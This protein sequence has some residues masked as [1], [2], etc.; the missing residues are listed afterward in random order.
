MSADEERILQDSFSGMVSLTRDQ[1]IVR[2]GDHPTQCSLLMDGYVYRYKI[3]PDGKRQILAF[4]FR[5]EIFDTQSFL[6]DT[7]DH[8]VA[9]LTPATIGVVTHAAMREITERFPRITRALWKETLAE[10]AIFR[11]WLVSVGRRPAYERLA[12]L[13]CETYVRSRSVE[14]GTRLS[15]PWPF[16]QIELGDALGLTP[17]HINRTLQALRNDGLI[18]LQGGVL[19]ILDWP[20]LM[21]ASEFDTCYLQLRDVVVP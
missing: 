2:D 17:I 21:Q 15:I 8:G 6:L 5:G 3:L 9:T 19:D 1:D 12:H 14:L 7:M 20:G 16:T 10:A 13:I 18:R 4:H 11:Q